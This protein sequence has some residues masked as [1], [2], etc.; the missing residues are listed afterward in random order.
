MWDFAGIILTSLSI[1][2]A[3]LP[4][5][6]LSYDGSA[7]DISQF[8][9]QDIPNVYF[10]GHYKINDTDYITWNVDTGTHTDKLNSIG[11]GVGWTHIKPLNDIWSINT[12]ISTRHEL[13]THTPCTDD[14]NR[15]YYCGSLTAF[16]DIERNEH[17]FN[18]KIS[19][20]LSASW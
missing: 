13:T 11:A 9:E 3:D 2:Y 6:A 20:S 18:N 10:G 7:R 12:A 5:Y 17:V 8:Y 19:I 14:Y 1:G 4:D 16:S 15:E